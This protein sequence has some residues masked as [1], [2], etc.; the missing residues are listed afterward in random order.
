[1]KDESK[2]NPQQIKDCN[3]KISYLHKE[4]E[5]LTNSLC[6][7]EAAVAQ[8]QGELQTHQQVAIPPKQLLKLTMEIVKLEH[9]LQKAKE[10][11]QQTELERRGVVHEMKAWQEVQHL[12]KL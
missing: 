4:I 12:G 3:A 5:S 8:L 11:K 1:M 9:R 2:L 10:Q 6:E 7:K